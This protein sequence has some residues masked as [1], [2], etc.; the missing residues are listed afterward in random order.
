MK[1]ILI[2]GGNIGRADT[3]YETG[4]IDEDVVKLS[5]K[6]NPNFLF[7]GL[8][9]S[10]SDSYYKII[11]EIYSNLGCTTGKISN[12]T[13]KN[14]DV[15][16]D[17]INNADIIYIGGGDTLKLMHDINE[18]NMKEMFDTAIKH[19]CVMVGVSAGAISLC[20]Y[21]LSDAEINNNIS[22]NYVSV[23]GLDYV[24]KMF[25][26]HFDTDSKKEDDLK[27]VIKGTNI[28]ALCLDNGVAIK[29][30]D[31]KETLIT[32]I[33]GKKAYTCYYDN[34]KFIKEEIK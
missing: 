32:S 21:G 30:V 23:D 3:K 26:P 33:S 27:K 22:N 24:D 31:D 17:K 13:L 28:K 9:S 20:K 15:V 16:K 7:V 34:N 25:V 14:N 6:N 1:M 12:K 29:I 11:K 4:K 2:G 18:N 19:N 10:F 8:A 5:G